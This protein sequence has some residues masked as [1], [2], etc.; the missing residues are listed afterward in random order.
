MKNGLIR[1]LTLLVI[2]ATVL[3]FVYMKLKEGS[4][5]S[6]EAVV[7]EVKSE[8]SNAGRIIVERTDEMYSD[9][10]DALGIGPDT[11]FK[12]EKNSKISL[13]DINTGDKIKVKALDAF[14]EEE[15]F[16]YPEVYSITLIERQ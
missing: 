16:F 14:T 11:V 9:S 5:I 10:L 8:G 13:S 1:V 2:V 4:V 15:I 7:T 12:D 6:F 3:G